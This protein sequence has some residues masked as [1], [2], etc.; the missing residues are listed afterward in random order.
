MIQYLDYLG[1]KP[2]DIIIVFLLA[3]PKKIGK[4]SITI[5]K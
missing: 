3:T 5:W 4:Q 2:W 1:Y